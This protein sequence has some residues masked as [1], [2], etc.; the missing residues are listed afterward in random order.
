MKKWQ[1]VLSLAVTLVLAS[2]A[3]AQTNVR[4][5]GT[6]T[7]VEGN[8]LSVKSRDGRDLK[9]RLADDVAGRR[10]KA[11]WLETSSLVRR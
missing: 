3:E 9:I 4:I 10:P 8:V 1:I 6:I 11:S 7:A 5:R 2:A